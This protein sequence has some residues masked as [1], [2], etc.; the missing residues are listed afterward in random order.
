LFREKGFDETTVE[1]IAEAAD[2]SPRTFFRYFPSKTAT[3]FAGS[4]R[5]ARLIADAVAG[6]QP[7]PEPSTADVRA[8]TQA[9]ARA[10]EEERSWFLERHLLISANPH[11]R[12]YSTEAYLGWTRAFA[13]ALGG[14]EWTEEPLR[15]RVLSALAMSVLAIALEEWL[16][17]ANESPLA[18]LVEVGFTAIGS[19]ATP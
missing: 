19:A 13:Q 14:R 3:L 7:A 17:P 16:S 2:V 9:F 4:D 5:H 1:D 11:L 10:I 8:A 6:H 15:I 18:S 12:Q